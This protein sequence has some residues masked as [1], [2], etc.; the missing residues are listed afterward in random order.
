MV[1]KG[2]LQTNIRNT[3]PTLQEQMHEDSFR[4]DSDIGEKIKSSENHPQSEMVSLEP[5]LP[6][7]RTIMTVEAD[8]SSEGNPTL[9]TAEKPLIQEKS[10]FEE[11]KT[12]QKPGE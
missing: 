1:N 11:R 2:Q 8:E 6:Q 10:S 9:R 4:D 12:G 7:K 3:V 5:S